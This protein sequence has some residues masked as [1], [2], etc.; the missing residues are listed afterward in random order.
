MHAKPPEFADILQTHGDIA[1]RMACH[2]TQG[3]EALARDLVQEAFIKIWK[4]WDFQRPQSFN[5]WLYRILHNLHMDH[6]R[7]K[8]R[9]K[10]TSYDVPG[11]AE[12]DSLIDLLPAPGLHSLELLEQEELVQIVRKSLST[13][14][15]EFRIPVILCDMEGLSYEEIALGMA[16]PVGT[17]RSRIHR[18]RRM[19]RG[20]LDQPARAHAVHPYNIREEAFA[21]VVGAAGGRPALL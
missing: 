2:L 13:L 10:A 21:G 20:L 6:L 11:P 3:D 8:T 17:V 14:P 12:D 9:E 1:Y 7:R 5:A 18:G 19:L 15:E 4:H 16:C